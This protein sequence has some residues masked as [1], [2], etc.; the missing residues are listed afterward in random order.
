MNQTDLIKQIY[1]N[2]LSKIVDAKKFFDRPLTYTEKILFSH[3]SEDLQSVPERTKTF[4]I[5]KPDRVA[6]QLSLIHI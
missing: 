4:C 2:Y 5:L 3:L 1:D 6:L